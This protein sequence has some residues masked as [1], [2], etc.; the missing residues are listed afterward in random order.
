MDFRTVNPLAF[1][2]G[3]SD[4]PA[5]K[6]AE[7]RRDAGDEGRSPVAEIDSELQAAIEYKIALSGADGAEVVLDYLNQALRR[8][9]RR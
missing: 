8:C 6:A 5:R 3:S 2:A 1:E 4:R 7:E 9:N